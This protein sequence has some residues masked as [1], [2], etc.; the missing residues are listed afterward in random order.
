MYSK[1]WPLRPGIKHWQFIKI[2]SLP[3]SL[4]LSLSAAGKLREPWVDSVYCSPLF[5]SLPLCLF[6]PL[7]WC[8]SAASSSEG[9]LQDLTWLPSCKNIV[10][11]AL[12]WSYPQ[13]KTLPKLSFVLVAQL[14][15]HSYL[16]G[17]S[18]TF[19]N[20]DKSCFFVC[21]FINSQ[22]WNKSAAVFFKVKP[23]YKYVADKYSYWC[24]RQKKMFNS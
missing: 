10:W 14:S 2:I 19:S 5:Y 23:L 21:A 18:Q 6:I 16:L 15:Y 20:W 8:F 11:S 4:S 7:I 22:K 1:A 12:L 17:F 3:L 24:N 9:R 13:N